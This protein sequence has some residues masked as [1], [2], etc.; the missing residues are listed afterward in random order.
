M[1]KLYVA[2]S[3]T[4]ISP[5]AGVR[6]ASPVRPVAQPADGEQVSQPAPSQSKNAE[7]GERQKQTALRSVFV[8]V[9]INLFLNFIWS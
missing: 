9:I 1:A 3:G 4:V 2:S 5:R 6:G 7:A 8:C